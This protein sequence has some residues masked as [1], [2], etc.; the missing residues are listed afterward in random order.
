MNVKSLQDKLQSG[1]GRFADNRYIRAISNGMVMIMAPI[2]IGSI[3]TLLG[4]LPISGYSKFLEAHGISTILNLVPDFTTNIM[5]LLAVFFIAYS[6]A[7]L[8]DKDGVVAGM[9]ALISFFIVTPLSSTKISGTMTD[10]ISFDWIGE[11]GLFVAIIIGLCVA[12]L[13]VYFMDKGFTI[14]MP[15]GV[16]SAVSA[17]FSG[18][19]PGFVITVL[20]LVVTALFKL[21]PFGSLDNLVYTCVQIPFQG[22]GSTFGAYLVVIIAVGILWFFGLHGDN[23]IIMGLMYPIYLALDMQ[24]LK[25]YQAGQMLP[26]IIGYQFIVTYTEVAGT[27]ITIGLALLMAFKAK[28]KQYRI[29][30]KLAIPT[31]CFEINEPVIFGTPIVLNPI[32]FV[33]FLLTPVIGSTLAYVATAIGLVPRLNGVQI[34]WSTPPIISGFLEGDWRT[35]VLQVIIIVLSVLI[36]YIPFKILD[37]RT[38]ENEQKNAEKENAAEMAAKAE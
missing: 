7:I 12:R 36:Y 23:I 32:M 25:A 8:F 35:A 5:A 14:K 10:Y 38:Y 13:Y 34:P 24:N 37:Q 4:N 30:G 3:F 26:N 9:L 28:S 11:K 19:I 6:L 2:I 18:L 20:S 15:K 1:V 27:G 31:A 21:T 17:S 29:V 33:P 22:I 16:P